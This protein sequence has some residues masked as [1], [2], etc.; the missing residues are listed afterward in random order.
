MA[1][2]RVSLVL[3]VTGQQA[4]EKAAKSVN[5][6]EQA[7][8]KVQRTGGKVGGAFRGMGAAANAAKPAIGG[9][10]AALTAALGPLA[11]ITSAAALVGKALNT[12]FERG[13]AEQKLRNFTDSTEEYNAALAV[14][15]NTASKFGMSQTE[16]TAALA[17]TYSRLKGLGF[18]L[19]ET[20]EIYSGFQSI[21]LQS[22]TSA[23]DAAGAFLQLSQALGSGKLQGDELRAILER[24]PQLAQRIADSM[25][26][27]AAEIRKMGQE[28]K[29]TSEIIYKALSEA[30][31]AADGFGSKLNEQQAAMKGLG[32]ATDQAFAMLGEA[33]SP[34]VVATAEALSWAIEKMTEW[35]DYLAANV[36]PKVQDALDPLVKAF[37]DAFSEEDLEYMITIIQNVLL[38]VLNETIW[39]VGELSKITA[40]VINKFKELASNPVFQVQF[41]ILGKIVDALGLTSNAVEEFNEEQKKVTEETAKTAENYSSLPDKVKD[42]KKEAKELAAA[43]K[44]VTQAIRE[45]GAEVEKTFAAQ[46]SIADAQFE[47]A[48]QRLKTEMAVNQVLLEQAERQ[49]DGAK[50]AAER[51]KAAKKVYDITVEQAKLEAQIAKAAIAESV[52]KAEAQVQML[53]LKAKEVAVVVKLAEANK[54]V[55]NE[56]YEAL[57][58]IKQTI[59]QAQQ[60]LDY[61]KQIAEEQYKEVDA[62]LKGKEAAAKAAYEQN[63]VF[64][65]TKGAAGAANDFANNMSEAANQAERTAKAMKK[66]WEIGQQAT[67]STSG[68]LPAG[69]SS[70]ANQKALASLSSAYTTTDDRGQLHLDMG[71]IKRLTMSQYQSLTQ[72]LNKRRGMYQQQ[73]EGQEERMAQAM[74]VNA[75]GGGAANTTINYNGSTVNFDGKSYVQKSDVNGIVNTAVNQTMNTLQRSSSARL[76]AGIR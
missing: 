74:R 26:V 58:L 60:Q 25:G 11:A 75:G 57:G 7:A 69:I 48:E 22:G 61:R 15:A 73:I 68:S 52:R 64:E 53:E 49:L 59:G 44:Q 35:W 19:K 40:I 45:A 36:F 27:S 10:G 2:Q 28:G 71:A 17:D 16:A 5:K 12:A 30:G 13:A 20:S 41:A 29:I 62:I 32:A 70:E 18:G 33:L 6:V 72:D 46:E 66:S 3:S 24:M 55:T 63:R 67:T 1:E 34:A 65:A 14:A 23:E 42:A 39:V 51:E 54:S 76:Q 31:D 9:L 43:Q 50:T 8:N 21:V 56:H 47:L 38:K 37:Q 4:F